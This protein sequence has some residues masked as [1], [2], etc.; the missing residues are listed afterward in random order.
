MFP[1]LLVVSLLASTFL[2]FH[3]PTSVLVLFLS[4]TNTTTDAWCTAEMCTAVV[5]VSLP[6]LKSL[7]VR[8]APTN[9]SNRSNTGYLQPG[10][11][12][13]VSS[14]RDGTYTAHIQ[15]GTVDEEEMELTLLDRKASLTPTGTT[16]ETKT[17]DGKDN[18]IV[19]TN[20]TVTRDVL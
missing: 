11:G 3:R 7:I 9:T 15:G 4:S 5:V 6:S 19:T 14:S 18:V 1:M 12:K 8:T 20:V 17:Q 13:P 2:C 16:D 10:S